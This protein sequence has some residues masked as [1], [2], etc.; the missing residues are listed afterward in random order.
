METVFVCQKLLW[1]VRV[2][3]QKPKLV[4]YISQDRQKM[5]LE[6]MHACQC[7]IPFEI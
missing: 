6:L 7:L 1:E 2:T 4:K 3:I 5:L